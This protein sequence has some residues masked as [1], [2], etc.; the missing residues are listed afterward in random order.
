MRGHFSSLA[1]LLAS[2]CIAHGVPGGEP[3]YRV[4]LQVMEDDW[5]G[6][7]R[8]DIGRGR[9]L[10]RRGT[11]QVLSQ[12]KPDEIRLAFSEEGPIVLYERGLA[13]HIKCG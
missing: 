6:A 7:G 3:T 12:R 5:G 2:I 13:R 1:G 8:E 10:R 4:Q 11:G 9:Q